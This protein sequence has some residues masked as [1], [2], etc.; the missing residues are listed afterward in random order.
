V[1]RDLRSQNNAFY[2]P[3]TTRFSD[4]LGASFRERIDLFP[5][6]ASTT[7]ALLHSIQLK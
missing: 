4:R 7:L 5:A 2:A 6:L 1:T 3:G